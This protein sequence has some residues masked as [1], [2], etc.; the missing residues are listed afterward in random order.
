[1]KSKLFYS[2][3]LI[4]IFIFSSCLKERHSVR[5]KNEYAY[6]VRNFTAGTANIGDVASGATSDYKSINT[7]NFTISGTTSNGQSVAGSGSISGKGTHK[8]TITLGA[9]G[10]CSVKED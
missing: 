2:I 4:G 5:L 6:D 7:G 1:M 9:N 3:L 8:W 10:T